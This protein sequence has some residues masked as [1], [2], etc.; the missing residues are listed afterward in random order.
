[1]EGKDQS[2]VR[3][4]FLLFPFPTFHFVSE[5]LENFLNFGPFFLKIILLDSAE[6]Y[7]ILFYFVYFLFL[8]SLHNEKNGALAGGKAAIVNVD[9]RADF[10]AQNVEGKWG[11]IVLVA[12]LFLRERKP[13]APREI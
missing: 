8:I 6:K 5:I 10:R 2:L 12:I 4:E 9:E 7:I 13:Y 1:M 11:R 3:G